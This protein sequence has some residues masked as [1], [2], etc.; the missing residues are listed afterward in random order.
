M[1]KGKQTASSRSDRASSSRPTIALC[2]AE[3]DFHIPVSYLTSA[4]A[5]AQAADMNFLYFS[6][7]PVDSPYYFEIQANLFYA[8]LEAAGVD[9]ILIPS[10]LVGLYH[11]P[12]EMSAFFQRYRPVPMVSMGGVLDGIPSLIVDNFTGMHAAI[13]HLIEVHGYRRIAFL[14]GVR[15][16]QEAQERY[17]AYTTA[18]QE[19][20][21]PFDEGLV[22][23]GNFQG[24]F[25]PKA[26]QTWL[27]ERGYRPRQDIEAIVAANDYMAIGVLLEL[28]QRG[29]AVPEDVA[30]V[31][32]DDIVIART[33][34]P[35][36]TTVRQ[37]FDTIGQQAMKLL[38]AKLDGQSVPEVTQVPARLV[39]RQSCGC[40]AAATHPDVALPTRPQT[41]INLLRE[42]PRQF[43]HQL[44][45]AMYATE[46]SMTLGNMTILD[47]ALSL[48]RHRQ[49]GMEPDTTQTTADESGEQ[50]RTMLGQMMMLSLQEKRDTQI[51]N[52][53]GERIISTLKVSELMDALA[54]GLP[55]LGIRSG[56]DSQ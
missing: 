44:N 8:M 1:D 4:S 30:I 34:T 35:P 17:R 53:L 13:S 18:L 11:S 9:G 20:G 52:G 2:G 23:H 36:L 38:L 33:F 15:E 49:G 27:D 21:I 32:F 37:P 54:G 45:Q 41:T 25:G 29:I 19:H 42:S 16:N 12:A 55:Q 24:I 10:N 39:V 56:S 50:L 31:G 43:F 26:V 28:Q 22:V 6:S 51:L 3:L 47:E 40:V 46:N 14:G 7:Q 48:L 5:I